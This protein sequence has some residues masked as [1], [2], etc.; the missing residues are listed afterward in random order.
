MRFFREFHEQ[1]RFVK[2][3]NA[4]F[5]VLMPKKGGAQDL[6]DFKPISLIGSL[7]KL[8]AKVLADRLQKV[9]SKVVSKFLKAFVEGR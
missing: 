1:G 9:A 5:L 2:S 3:L 6:K 7:S 8:L 4:T